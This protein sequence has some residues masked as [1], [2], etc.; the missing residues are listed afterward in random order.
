MLDNILA[1]LIPLALIAGVA[2]GGADKLKEHVDVDQVANIVEIVLTRYELGGITHVIVTHYKEKRQLPSSFGFDVFLRKN[3]IQANETQ[4][5]DPSRDY[6]DMSYRFFPSGDSFQLRSCGPDKKCGTKDDIV[7]ER[8]NL[9][10]VQTL[11][12]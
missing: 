7:V 10:Q 9:K 1:K 8:R 2:G 6:W 12:L 4:T 11:D 5:R 3:M